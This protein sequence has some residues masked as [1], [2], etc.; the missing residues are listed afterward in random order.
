MTEPGYAVR[1][2]PRVLVTIAEQ[3]ARGV[4]GVARLG[5]EPLLERLRHGQV[6][7]HHVRLA[8]DQRGVALDLFVVVA[9]GTPVAEV[10]SRLQQAVAQAIATQTGLAVRE[11]N[12]HVQRLV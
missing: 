5:H 7:R 11:V 12:V 2:A 8:V 4:P 9:P 3:A 6:R 1:I 10:V